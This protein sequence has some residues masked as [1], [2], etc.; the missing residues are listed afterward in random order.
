MSRKTLALQKFYHKVYC[1][2]IISRGFDSMPS[3]GAMQVQRDLCSIVN[4]Q[5]GNPATH[6]KI[7]WYENAMWKKF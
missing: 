2:S 7:S 3:C 6:F 5:I 4:T 1:E